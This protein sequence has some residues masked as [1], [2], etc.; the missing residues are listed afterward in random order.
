MPPR[1]SSTGSANNKKIS[2]D[3]KKIIKI[4]TEKENEYKNK[5]RPTPILGGDKYNIWMYSKVISEII[6][7]SY[8][9]HTGLRDMAEIKITSDSSNKV[10]KAVKDYL[11][12][13]HKDINLKIII[14]EEIN[15]THPKD[16][17]VYYMYLSKHDLNIN[18]DNLNNRGVAIADKLNEGQLGDF[19]T[20]KSK[21]DDWKTYEWRILIDCDGSEILAQM[22]KPEQIETNIKKTMDI[23]QKILDAFKQLDPMRFSTTPPP[24]KL[25]IYKTT[26]NELSI[27]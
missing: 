6:L 10:L 26:V 24:L 7:Q 25:N 22:C 19:Y 8:L 20:C 3:I 14:N 27:I 23:Y 1:R 4:Y 13:Y 11:D 17:K 9:I 16:K 12:L 15:I 18:K 2:P 21:S 5:V